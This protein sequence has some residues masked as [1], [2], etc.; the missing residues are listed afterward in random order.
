MKEY[1]L[2]EEAEKMLENA[3]IISDGEYCGY[4]TEDVSISAIPAADVVEVVRCCDCKHFFYESECSK[5]SRSGS[6][7]TGYTF[8][9]RPNNFCSYGERR[10]NGR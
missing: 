5:H 10:D 7:I 6:P 4:C 2:R 9:T 1:I 3:Q 8:Y